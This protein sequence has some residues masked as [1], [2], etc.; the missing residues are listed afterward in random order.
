M[1]LLQIWTQLL[2][3]QLIIIFQVMYTCRYQLR[4]VSNGFERWFQ[5][6]IDVYSRNAIEKVRN[7]LVFSLVLLVKCVTKI[8]N[9]AG[10]MRV[11]QILKIWSLLSTKSIFSSKQAMAQTPTGHPVYTNFPLIF[12][13]KQKYTKSLELFGK[14]ASELF[15]KCNNICPKKIT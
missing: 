2:N 13:S 11:H 9:F 5:Q 3:P 7:Y 1:K 15:Q 6:T 10:F 4:K 14:P 12:L 8:K